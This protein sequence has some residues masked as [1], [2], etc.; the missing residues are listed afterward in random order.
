MALAANV[1]QYFPPKR[2]QQMEDDLC[3]LANY[4]EE[5]PWGWSLCTKQRYKKMGIKE[6]DLPSDEW[7]E[8]VRRLSS[9]EF[10]CNYISHM[11]AELQDE[12]LVGA[13]MSFWKSVQPHHSSCTFPHIFKS[14]WSSSGRG[15]FTSHHLSADMMEKKLQGFINSQG[16]YLADKFY[17]KELDFAMEFFVHQDH[18]VEFLGFSVFHA[19]E[20]GAYGYNIVEDQHALKSYISK[21]C[22]LLDT[23][24]EY[25]KTHLALTSYHGP[26]G[27]DMLVCKDDKIHPCI[28]INLRM[29]MG[30]LAILLYN[31]YGANANIQLTPKREHGF[32]A[33]VENG[34]LMITYNR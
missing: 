9:R 26:V 27:I 28:E 15:V 31:K 13:N 19:E 21:D 20:T 24:I 18:M 12:R 10:A 6:D 3:S 7:I 32:E 23:L 5:G 33:K 29:N 2:I 22:D 14:P 25:H 34:K 4:W 8:E 1:P 11:L 17:E 30:I 16:G